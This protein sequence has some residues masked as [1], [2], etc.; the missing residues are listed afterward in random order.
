MKLFSSTRYKISHK[1]APFQKK[2]TLYTTQPTPYIIHANTMITENFPYQNP[3][4]TLYAPTKFLAPLLRYMLILQ[5]RLIS[6]L[7]Y[8]LRAARS[9]IGA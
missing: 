3:D 6:A 7:N 4:F 5:E 8:F 1:T 9:F 2:F